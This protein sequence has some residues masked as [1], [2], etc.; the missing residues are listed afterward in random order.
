[1][2][3]EDG[4]PEKAREVIEQAI[5]I[6]PSDGEQGPG[7][8]MRAY[9]VLSDV[10]RALGDAENAKFYGG[11]TEAIRLAE[12]ADKFRSAGL[13][14]RGIELYRKS[15]THFTDAYCIQSRLALELADLGR[16]DEAAEHYRR[17]YEL[18]P[19]SFGRV[20]SH[21]FGCEG[22]FATSFARSIAEEVFQNLIEQQPQN[23]QVHYLMGYLHDTQGRLPEATEHYRRAVELDLQYLNAWKE[24]SHSSRQLPMSRKQRDRITLKIIE[25]DPLRRHSYA[26]PDEVFDVD[27]MW[28][29]I[30][31]ARSHLTVP[32]ESLLELP[33]ARARIEHQREQ[34]PEH[35]QQQFND[36]RSYHRDG[37]GTPGEVLAEHLVVEAVGS[38]MDF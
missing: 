30:E 29:A 10:L 14:S 19:S 16:M 35:L 24:L 2:L 33:A 3:L 11:V 38:T 5:A 8:R 4:Q 36:Y 7:D 28:H 12:Q 23:P 26:R 31:D 9:E 25:L 17:A 18:M 21:C 22:I 20:E 27:S 32:P 37:W 34:M 1:M 13:L 6:D 15:L